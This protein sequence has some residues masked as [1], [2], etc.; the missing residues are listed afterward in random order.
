MEDLRSLAIQLPSR[1][2]A[3]AQ[4]RQ[5]VYA[6]MRGFLIRLLSLAFVG[7][8]LAVFLVLDRRRPARAVLGGALNA[9]ILIIVLLRAYGS[10]DLGQLRDHAEYR[11][12]LRGARM[13]VKLVGVGALNLGELDLGVQNTARAI[14]KLYDQ[15][16]HLNGAT[17]PR[18]LTRILVISDIHNNTIAMRMA[19]TLARL[20]DVDFVLNAGDLTELGTNFET[21]LAVQVGRLPRPHVFV[22][23]NHDSPQITAALRRLSNTVLPN[24]RVVSVRGFRI[25]GVNDPASPRSDH[26]LPSPSQ[27]QIVAARAGIRRTLARRRSTPDILLVHSDLVARPFFGKLPIVVCGH[28]HFMTALSLGGNVAVNPGSTGMSGLRFLSPRMPKAMSAVVLYVTRSP[29]TRAVAADL[30]EVTSPA[31]EFTIRRKRF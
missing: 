8:A 5:Q 25:L 23:G 11:G 3:L 17:L 4:A 19:T 29:R 24:G 16:T 15:L 28:S 13:A 14:V 7:G 21:D 12:G 2:L 6:A 27:A 31:G 22:T 30:I 26:R 9:V 18:N 1:R 20:Y 10:Y